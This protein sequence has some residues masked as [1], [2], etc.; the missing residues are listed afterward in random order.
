M[1]GEVATKL[2]LSNLS[3]DDK[4]LLC[5]LNLQ[6]ESLPTNIPSVPPERKD[7]SNN[8][9]Y[10]QAELALELSDYYQQLALEASDLIDD[11]DVYDEPKIKTEA[12]TSVQ[13]MIRHFERINSKQ[14][15]QNDEDN[16]C[17]DEDIN[18]KKDDKDTISP[19]KH[20]SRKAYHYSNTSLDYARRALEKSDKAF[21]AES[22]NKFLTETHY[23]D[24]KQIDG[25]YNAFNLYNQIRVTFNRINGIASNPLTK[26]GP[27]I[28]NPNIMGVAGLAWGAEF[29]V[30]LAH[31]SVT[32]FAPNKYELNL[33]PEWDWLDRAHDWIDKYGLNMLNAGTYFAAN[34]TCLFLAF[35]NFGLKAIPIIYIA[36]SVY[37]VVEEIILCKKAYADVQKYKH[38]LAKI[39]IQKTTFQADS[40]EF[41]NLQLI[42]DKINNKIKAIKRERFDGLLI[43]SMILVATAL[44][45][46]V[47][48]EI[49]LAGAIIA[50]VFGSIYG[51]L[52]RRI[53]NNVIK[54]AYH[55]TE[56]HVI[57]AVNDH[58]KKQ[59]HSN[60][61]TNLPKVNN[62]HAA[63]FNQSKTMPVKA[64]ATSAA[65]NNQV[66]PTTKLAFAS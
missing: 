17:D 3:I 61:N 47:A 19:A 25:V 33:H 36:S 49:A 2:G 54:P 23:K 59:M 43:T 53:L 5:D 29:A 4:K 65:E 11:V 32:A 34:A 14:F 50:L 12:I 1:S 31:L 40:P 38:L 30:D 46:F 13:N 27:L 42:Q 9:D 22:K 62:V 57:S 39:E 6:S 15:N 35:K 66:A 56:D 18:P 41:Q 24:S 52:G 44:S 21:F 26:V 63:F 16:S 48:P 64:A 55:W 7:D 37:D 20:K 51:G 60:A 45:L 8:L 10:L 58:V 28:K